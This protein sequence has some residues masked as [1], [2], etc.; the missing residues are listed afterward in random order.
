MR[1]W[2]LGGN[3]GWRGRSRIGNRRR[4]FFH[5][6]HMALGLVVCPGFLVG[7]RCEVLFHVVAGMTNPL[8][9]N[10]ALAALYAK[11]DELA[12]RNLDAWAAIDAIEQEQAE[13][14][15]EIDRESVSE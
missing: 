1:F 2:V 13:V 5:S 10:P 11:A 8:T 12:L 9:P 15:R 3:L 7:R 6:R 14:Q 4:S